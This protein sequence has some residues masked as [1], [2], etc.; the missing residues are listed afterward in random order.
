M[1]LVKFNPFG[2]NVRPSSNF[3]KL[4]NDFFNTD[5]DRLFDMQLPSFLGG[6]T[7]NGGV[8]IAETETSFDLEVALPGFSKEDYSLSLEGDTLNISAEKRS[9]TETTD[10]NDKKYIRR[11]FGYSSFK[12]SYQLPENIDVAN[13]A[14]KFNNGMLLVTLPKL[15]P[16]TTGNQ[17]TTI[18]IS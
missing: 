14:A 2:V 16:E 10:E 15:T 12:R 1:S 8:N 6:A 4:V 9:K 18:E 11:E 3:D 7:A 17:A 5:F 13:I